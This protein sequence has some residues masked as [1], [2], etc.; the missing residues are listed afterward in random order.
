MFGP[1]INSNTF[2]HRE[3]E[4]FVTATSRVEKAF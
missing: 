3:G 1:F 2:N 4:P